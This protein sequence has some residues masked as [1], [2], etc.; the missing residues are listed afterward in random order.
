MLSPFHQQKRAM[1]WSIS[2][3]LS[4]AVTLEKRDRKPPLGTPLLRELIFQ[5]SNTFP[6]S[7]AGGKSNDVGKAEAS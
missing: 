5:A 4:V 6:S 3:Q 7:P 2:K 1:L